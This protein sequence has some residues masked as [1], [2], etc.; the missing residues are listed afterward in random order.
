MHSFRITLCVLLHALKAQVA[1][2][3]T[4]GMC[5]PISVEAGFPTLALGISPDLQ[6]I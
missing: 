1:R 2:R 5:L 3:G 6:S 4:R